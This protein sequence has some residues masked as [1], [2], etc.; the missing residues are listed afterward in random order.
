[1]KIF[2]FLLFFSEAMSDEDLMCSI[3]EFQD[4][5]FRINL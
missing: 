4:I 1:M 5:N 2:F 3:F